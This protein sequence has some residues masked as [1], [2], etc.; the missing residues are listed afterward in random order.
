VP[1]PL[2]DDFPTAAALRAMSLALYRSSDA[3]L[4]NPDA[5][6]RIRRIALGRLIRGLPDMRKIIANSAVAA[7][8]RAYLVDLIARLHGP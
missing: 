4:N 2:R 7:E 3:S 8:D 5:T 6:P 1:R